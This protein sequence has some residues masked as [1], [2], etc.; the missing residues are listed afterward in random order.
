MLGGNLFGVSS[1]LLGLGDAQLAA[2]LR[3]DVLI[4][5]RG[6]RR[7]YDAGNGYE[8]LY[9]AAW[10][11]DQRLYRRYA[12]RVESPI[13]PPSLRDAARARVRAVAEPS[14]AFGPAGGSGEENISVIVAPIREGFR[15]EGMGSPEQ[16]G[17]D[18]LANTVAPAGSDR[19]AELLGASSRVDAGGELYYTMEFTVSSPRFARHN[20]AAYAARNGLLYTLNCQC[21]ERDWARDEEGFRRAAASF[22]IISSGAGA[23]GFPDRL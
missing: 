7:C 1:F 4:P 23:A 22:A 19:R 12:V 6:Y 5:V 3:L 10:L 21:A 9:P 11:A 20:L 14:A 15:L 13:D 16:A 17:R 2:A 8:F 18:F